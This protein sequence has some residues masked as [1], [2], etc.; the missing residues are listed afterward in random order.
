MY[1][2]DVDNLVNNRGV[3]KNDAVIPTENKYGD[4][5]VPDNIEAREIG[6]P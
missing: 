6:K 5:I 3:K 2:E 4:I 1:L